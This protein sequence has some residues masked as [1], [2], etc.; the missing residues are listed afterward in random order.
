MI[1]SSPDFIAIAKYAF[2]NSTVQ[3]YPFFEDFAR[4]FSNY[5]PSLIT[6]QKQTPSKMRNNTVLFR[7]LQLRIFLQNIFLKMPSTLHFHR[8]RL[9]FR[10][11]TEGGDDV[12]L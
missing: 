11:T 2:D 6:F 7:K 5:P 4:L 8:K 12:K 10:A 3:K 1:L 9:D